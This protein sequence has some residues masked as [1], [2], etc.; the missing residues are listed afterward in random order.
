MI[1]LLK[2]VF[3]HLVDEQWS[4]IRALLE[5]LDEDAHKSIGRLQPTT[6]KLKREAQLVVLGMLVEALLDPHEAASAAAVLADLVRRGGADDAAAAIA[7][8]WAADELA[9]ARAALT[10]LVAH[11]TRPGAA[12]ELSPPPITNAPKTLNPN[13][14]RKEE[15]VPTITRET[16]V[17]DNRNIP[18]D[19]KT[20]DKQKA[21]V[22]E[23]TKALVLRL[24]VDTPDPVLVAAVVGG[25]LRQGQYNPLSTSLPL[26]VAKLVDDLLQQKIDPSGKK[27]NA[28]QVY[29]KIVEIQLQQASTN[30]NGATPP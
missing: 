15:A 9:G 2:K 13:N 10:S 20:P 5:R 25:L 21:Y 29:Q 28:L 30:G 19:L 11:A 24:S 16:F 7:N 27:Y 17:F 12:T 6:P 14:P 18:D 26:L 1:A 23:V 22:D 4:T 8:G 3:P